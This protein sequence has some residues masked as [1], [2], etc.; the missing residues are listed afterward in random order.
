MSWAVNVNNGM[1]DLYNKIATLPQS[2]QDEIKRDL[3]ACHE[4]RPELAM[5]DSARGITNF[6]SPNDIIVDASMPA[7][8]RNSGKMWGADGRLKDVKGRDARVNLLPGYTR[9]SSTSASGMVPLI[10][11]PWARFPT[12]ASWRSRLRST[13]PRQ[14]L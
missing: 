6:H 4:H 2:K 12:L 11:R 14:D 1:G 10:R 9:R 3:H 8:I 13:A 5:V 7:M